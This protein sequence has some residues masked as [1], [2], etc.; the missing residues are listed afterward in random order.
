MSREC[1]ESVGNFKVDKGSVA[2][3]WLGQMKHLRRDPQRMPLP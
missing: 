3:W 1:M 2:L